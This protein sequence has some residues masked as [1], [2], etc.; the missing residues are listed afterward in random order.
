MFEELSYCQIV[1]MI[2]FDSYLIYVCGSA[3]GEIGFKWES[4]T[5]ISRKALTAS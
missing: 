5:F 3:Y 4:A 2:I 1:I